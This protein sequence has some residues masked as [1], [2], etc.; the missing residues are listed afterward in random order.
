[1]TSPMRG[2]PSS[3]NTSSSDFRFSPH[4][5][6]TADDVDRALHLLAAL[7]A[8]HRGRDKPASGSAR[9]I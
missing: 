4:L 2:G 3:G 7:P 6:K 8:R 9:A 1:M 5:Y